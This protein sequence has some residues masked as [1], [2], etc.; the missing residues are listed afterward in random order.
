VTGFFDLFWLAI[1]HDKSAESYAIKQKGVDGY[2]DKI[3]ET[4]YVAEETFSAT[5]DAAK[6]SAKEQQQAKPWIR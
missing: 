3:K 2:N 1:Y 4:N 5:A 6:R